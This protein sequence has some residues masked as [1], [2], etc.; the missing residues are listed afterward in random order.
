MA[1]DVAKDSTVFLPLE[2][3]GGPSRRA[4]SVWAESGHRDH[5]PDFSGL[6]DVS[7][8][9]GT[10]VMKPFCVIHHVFFPGLLHCFP[11]GG[12]LFHRRE[13][14]FVRKVILPRLHG[15]KPEG[16]A[17]AGHSCA[18]NHL[19]FRVLQR[20]LLAAG[21]QDLRKRFPE[22][23]HLFRIRIIHV[24]QRAAGFRQSVAHAVNMPVIQPDRG[25]DEFTGFDDRARFPFRRI[26]HAV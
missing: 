7:G 19:R 1:A 23:L 3:P 24:F 22:S 5:F 10:F 2:E 20:F 9:N 16:A 8:Q 18:G 21:R 26:I 11:G 25:K 13:R 15:P 6:G 12:Q 17:L 4:E 14:R